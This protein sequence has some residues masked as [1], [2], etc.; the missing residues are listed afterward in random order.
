MVHC[1]IAVAQHLNHCATTVPI[2]VYGTYLYLISILQKLVQN[3]FTCVCFLFYYCIFSP[4]LF[5]Y[6]SVKSLKGHLDT[7]FSGFF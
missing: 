2:I 5:I 4:H 6:R 7:C 1:S 3:V